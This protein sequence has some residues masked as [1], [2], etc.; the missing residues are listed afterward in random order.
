[1]HFD[2][3]NNHILANRHSIYNL[4]LAPSR[5]NQFFVIDV[6]ESIYCKKSN[7]K[8]KFIQISIRIYNQNFQSVYL[9]N[10]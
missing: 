3:I 2:S 9:Y 4:D 1:M 6:A 7:I 8:V 5:G 10:I